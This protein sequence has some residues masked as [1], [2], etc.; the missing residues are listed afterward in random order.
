MAM[1]LE[2]IFKIL[3]MLIVVAVIIGLILTFRDQIVALTKSYL[4]YFGGG[5]NQTPQFPKLIDKG[6]GTFLSGEVGSY[7]Q[8]C[9]TAINSLSVDQRVTTNCYILRGNFNANQDDIL[10][11]ITDSSLRDKVNITADFAKGAVIIQYLDPQGIV[12]VK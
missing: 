6:T 3:I 4:Q 9:Y 8:S 2:Y 7:V 11:S 10:K 1:E 5:N 12:L